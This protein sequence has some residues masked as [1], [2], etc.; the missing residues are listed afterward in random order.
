MKS[1]SNGS[2]GSPAAAG[3]V[4]AVRPWLLISVRSE[5]EID[6]AIAG[7]ADIIDLK[8]PRDGALAPTTIELWN[9]VSQWTDQVA[10][11]LPAEDRSESI[12]FSA[13]LGE[14]DQATSIAN[15]LPPTFAFAKVGPSN[16]NTPQRL[17]KLWSKVRDQL[18]SATELVAVAYADHR[19]ARCLPAE[20]V[21]K[22]AGEFGFKRCLIDTLNKDG[23][24]TVD[25]LGIDGVGRLASVARQEGLWWTLAGSIRLDQIERFDRNL[26]LPDCFGVRGDVCGGDR[27]A[28][29]STIRVR[30]WKQA[31][32]R[33]PNSATRPDL[34]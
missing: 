4:S 27:Q 29:L 34:R 32:T 11:S 26:I 23:R 21:F 25:H 5:Q 7:G 12:R 10:T 20:Q 18:N 28:V 1:R 16:C 3:S 14:S 2:A 6:D 9:S 17:T 15:S 33:Q 22:L 30:Q 8:E 31:C 24:T 13:A 19:S